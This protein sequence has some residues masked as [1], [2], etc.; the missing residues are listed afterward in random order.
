MIL[1]RATRAR[2]SVAPL[3]SL[4]DGLVPMVRAVNLARALEQ[5]KKEGELGRR[6][7]NQY[8]RYATVVLATFQAF[9]IA[10]MMEQAFDHLDAPVK[11]VCGLDIPLHE[12]DG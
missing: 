11:R 2:L 10:V 5:L 6:K 8:T 7:I 4:P 12:Q 3:G 1:N 9:G